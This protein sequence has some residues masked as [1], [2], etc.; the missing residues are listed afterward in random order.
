MSS[1][2][3]FSFFRAFRLRCLPI[4]AFLAMLCAVPA[5]GGDTAPQER[6]A[7]ARAAFEKGDF[8]KAQYLGEALVNEQHLSSA[9]F[10]LLGNTRY[11]QGDLGRAALYYQRAAMFPPPSAETRQNIAHIHDRTGNFF[12][13]ANGFLQQLAAWLT[14]SQ[15]LAVAV[16]CGWVLTLCS[17]IA[18][19]FLRAGNAR[20]VLLTVAL[21]A[22]GGETISALG[23]LW[24]PSF[25]NVRDLAVITSK[26]TR[27]YAGASITSS[28]LAQLPPGSQVRKIEDRDSWCY[29][30]FHN[31]SPAPEGKDLRGWV[32][33][34]S[35]T[36][37]W[38]YDPACLE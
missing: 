7:E 25:E 26:D 10:Q 5:R 30:E 22:L 38:P 11:R 31:E 35:L 23:W 1:P 9:L 34:E 17:V 36:P 13:P 16:A 28:S 21:L 14:R 3:P 37:L 24:H 33:T 12:F 6:F 15:W 27:A 29:V 4:A 2:G 18:F 8:A 19:F 32:Q 20:A